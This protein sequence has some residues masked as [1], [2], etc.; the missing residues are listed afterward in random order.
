MNQLTP[1]FKTAKLAS[2]DDLHVG[3]F[4]PRYNDVAHLVENG[5]LVYTYLDLETTDKDWKTAEITLA[6]L[7]VTDIGFNLI[8]DDLYEVCVPDRVGLSPEAMLIT[9]YMASK[10]RQKDRLPPQIAAAQIY[11]AVQD[12]PR[13][14]WTSLEKWKDKLGEENWQTYVDEKPIQ[15][16][17]RNS[18]EKE[19]LVRHFPMLDDK[20]RIIKNVRI[21][22]PEGGQEFMDMSY[23]VKGKGEFDYQDEQGNWKIRKLDKYNLGFRNTFFDNRLLAAALFRAN[24]PQKLIYALNKK[25][26]GNHAA[27]VFTMAISDHFFGKGGERKIKLGTRV[28]PETSREKISAKLDLLMEE[29]T[30]LGDLDIGMPEGVRVYDGTLHNLKRGHNAPDYDNAKSIGMHRYMRTHNP[31]IISHIERC[32]H[33][34]YMRRFMTHDM[35]DGIP[36]THPIRFGIISANDDQIY[37]A[38]PLII[39][40]SDDEH[41]KFKK[42]LTIRADFDFAEETYNGKNILDMSV[43]ELAEMMRVQK[44]QPDALFQEIHMKRH[45]GVFDLETGLRA[46][47]APGMTKDVFRYQRDMIVNHLDDHDRL[48]L[49]K[50]LDAFSLQYAF[51]P[52][53][54]DIPQPFV[55]EEIWTAMG[56][57]KYAH[58]TD[59]NGLPIKLPNIIR[60]MAQDEFKRLNDRIGDTLREL[61]RPQPLDWEINTANALAYMRHRAKQEKKL[62]DYQ[63]RLKEGGRINLPA[64]DYS[65]SNS[66][67]LSSKK[68]PEIS[69]QDAYSTLLQDRLYL[70]DKIH[71]TTRSYEVQQKLFSDVTKKFH[72]QTIPFSILSKMQESYLLNLR[73]EGR[74]RVIFE[75]NPNRPAFRF[76]IR[77]F[78]EN[79]MGDLLT[80]AQRDFYAAETAAYVHGPVYIPDPDQHRI[81]SIAKIRQSIEKIRQNIKPGDGFLSA[82]REGEKGAFSQYANDNFAESILDNVERDTKRRGRDYAFTDARKYLFSIHPD[83]N[84]PLLNVR[85]E[86]PQDHLKIIVPDAQTMIM[87]SHPQFGH[88]CII[89]PADTDVKR[90]R[91]IVIEEEKT[92]K[93]FYAADPIFHAFPDRRSGAYENFFKSIDNAYSAS[94]YEPPQNGLVLSCQ[95]LAPVTR[96]RDRDFPSVRIPMNRLLATRNA[97]LGN[98]Q[99]DEVLTGFILR[100][101][102]LRLKKGQ[103]IILRGVDRE[104]TETGWEAFAEISHKAQEFTLKEL[105]SLLDDPRKRDA[106]EKL[107]LKCGYGTTDDLKAAMLSEYTKFDEDILSSQNE[108]IFFDIKPVKAIHYWTPLQPRAA[109]ENNLLRSADRAPKPKKSKLAAKQPILEIN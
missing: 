20:N 91:H 90:S 95:E 57:I 59:R 87:A 109:F 89:V 1:V 74:L 4:L 29:N 66:E 81:M 52:P 17:R 37:R 45:R 62:E 80:Q 7:T 9:R 88:S 61:L 54:D 56:D 49:D 15:I 36:T 76:G 30:R 104:N 16:A 32:G 97:R 39:L 31:Q 26:L 2:N 68:M 73:D 70:M 27:D 40:G 25:A 75:E 3:V 106:A 94:G 83:T 86:I 63:S 35:E 14:L 92:K 24:F 64:P 103:K 22:E 47:H 98:L 43:E 18:G 99:R 100:K 82:T 55:E 28:D 71:E 41:G 67:I 19:T 102:D 50:A 46:G 85:Y 60:E 11:E 21:H 6:S 79:N 53:A 96:P 108:L 101:Y 69:V 105:I 78:V 58:V 38:V 84:E 77:Y 107:S 51:K 42:I 72:W 13:R 48:F 65:Y 12:T 23:L 5:A 10:L 34:D 33:V 8:S 93:K 44:G